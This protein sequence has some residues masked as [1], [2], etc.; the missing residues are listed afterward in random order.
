MLLMAKKTNNS[1]Y[2]EEWVPI[3][4][5]LNGMIQLNNGEFVTGV[6][7]DPKNIFILD[8]G[9]QNNV[10]FN[11]RNLY[12]IIDYEFWLIVADRPVDITV[13]QSELQVLYN[14]TQNSA[15]RKLIMQDINKANLFMSTTANIVD[16]E[17][18][19][20]FKSKNIEIIQKR[21]QTLIS[22]LANCSLVSRQVS[23]DDLRTLLDNFFNGGVSTNFGTVISV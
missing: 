20:L 23:N 4:Q 22:N 8:Q 18:F 7:I 10:I 21:I 15:I 14:N 17:Y 2:T 12:N 5:I 1:K 13:Y 19:I 16:I 3:R 11:F 6:K 9:T